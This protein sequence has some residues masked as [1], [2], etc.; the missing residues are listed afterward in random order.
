MLVY[1]NSC[2]YGVYTDG[3][4]YS[5]VVA[6]K[7]QADLINHGLSGSCNERIFRTSVRDILNLLTNHNAS[8]ILVLVGL[9]N[10]FRSEYWAERPAKHQDGHFKSFTASDQSGPV[11]KYQQEFYR[12]YDQEAAT[13]NLLHQ[14][15]MFTGFLQ[16]H[17]VKYLI[18][19]NTPHLKKIDF[20]ADFVRPFYHSISAN[21]NILPLFDFNFCDF[22]QMQ[23]HNTMDQP[24]NKG[25]HPCAEAHKDFADYILQKL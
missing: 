4:V 10:T 1:S 6:E 17:H 9:T 5:E 15:V 3:P 21:H 2:S 19:A 8:D 20:D 11:A 7:L 18:W 16:N 24:Y 25:G 23:G 12:L 22:A 13:T 14:L